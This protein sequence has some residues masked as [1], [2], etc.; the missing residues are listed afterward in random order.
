MRLAPNVGITRRPERLIY[1]RGGV[2]AVRCIGLF[3]GGN[4]VER[5]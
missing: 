2:S 5:L 4:P 1:I 3:G